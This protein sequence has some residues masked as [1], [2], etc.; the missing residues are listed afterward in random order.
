MP[1]RAAH[2]EHIASSPSSTDLPGA[3]R[4][5]ASGRRR[6]RG[7]TPVRHLL[8]PLGRTLVMTLLGGA[9]GAGDMPMC[10]ESPPDLT[11]IGIEAGMHT[12]VASVSE[13]PETL[14]CSA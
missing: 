14:M 9:A 11:V 7:A 13:K 5:P 3:R 4:R 10:Q 6:A 12:A 1:R 8:R 2:L